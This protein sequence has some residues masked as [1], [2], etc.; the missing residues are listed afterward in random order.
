MHPE[1]A[2]FVEAGRINQ[3]VGERISQLAPGNY[4][5]SKTWGA[6]KVVEW[7]LR[8]KK[9]TIDFADRTAQEMDLQFA[10]QKTDYLDASDFRAKKLEQ[11]EE[12]R[13]MAGVDAV[14]LVI[15]VLE[16]HQGS[17]TLD[18]FEKALCGT[19]IAEKDYKKWWDATKKSL[20]AG[21]RVVVPTKRTDQMCLRSGAMTPIEALLLDVSNARELKLK[22]KALEAIATEIELFS[23]HSDA[24]LQLYIEL[25]AEMRRGLRLNLGSV[26]EL[27][28]IR[29]QISRA[30]KQVV[31]SI[32]LTLTEVLQTEF[33]RV[34]EAIA[35]LSAARQREIYDIFPQSFGDNWGDKLMTIVEKAGARGV[36]EIA[37]I[38]DD[39]GQLP[40]LEE[41]LRKAITRRSLGHDALIWVCR[42]RKGISKV[43]FSAEV[44][45]AI[46]NQL[47]TDFIADGPRKAQR[48]Q[49]LMSEDKELIG[50]LVAMMDINEARNFGRRLMECPVFNDLDR[51]SLMARVIKARPET[52][53]LVSGENKRKKDE[54]LLVSWES[55]ER[56]KAEL[57]DLVRNRI[58]QNTKDISIARSYGDLRENFEY[59]SAKDM[60]T[61]LSNRKAEL[62][63][64]ISLARGTDFRDSD[65]SSVNIG[66]I[67]TIRDNNEITRTVTVLG[68]WDSDPEKKILSYLSEAGASLLGAKVGSTVE[69]RNPTTDVKE[70][71]TIIEIRPYATD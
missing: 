19:V 3:A 69:L 38:F 10:M 46:L 59:K 40:E 68:A 67:V 12:L 49:T 56:K 45:A 64:D 29:D 66:T 51:K 44:G 37:K 27:L 11:T 57:E 70:V 14:A 23:D 22:C 4:L 42:E 28:V 48:L 25:D 60:Q 2:K 39:Q 7:N 35:S 30:S 63:R 24:L 16:S 18:A 41:Y 15:H 52:A 54:V 20:A 32:C 13:H 61:F 71:W 33:N 47:E 62:E 50:D 5:L 9:L 17:M 65:A 31:P 36:G 21:K 1:V 26:L 58:P 6:G 34:A 55:L 43:I 8:D 53:E